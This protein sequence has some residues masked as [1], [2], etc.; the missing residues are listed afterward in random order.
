MRSRVS[1]TVVVLCSLDAKCAWMC[2]DVIFVFTSILLHFI[3]S[4]I[5]VGGWMAKWMDGW[6][7]GS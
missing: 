3:T 2:G 6:V 5:H 4:R 7:G 1:N